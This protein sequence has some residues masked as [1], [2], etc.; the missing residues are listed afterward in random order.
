MQT[1]LLMET[2]LEEIGNAGNRT[3]PLRLELERWRRE[4]DQCHNRLDDVSAVPMGFANDLPAGMVRG[5]LFGGMRDRI[6]V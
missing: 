3:K 2:H 4:L 1:D 5:S 6:K